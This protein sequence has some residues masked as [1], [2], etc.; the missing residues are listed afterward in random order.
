[1]FPGEEYGDMLASIGDISGESAEGNSEACGQQEASAH[2]SEQD[3]DS[4]ESLADLCHRHG[5]K[6][7]CPRILGTG[8]PFQVGRG[9][10]SRTARR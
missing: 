1:M 8:W 10:S 9:P 4:Q 6:P 7:P 5:T 2:K 3:A